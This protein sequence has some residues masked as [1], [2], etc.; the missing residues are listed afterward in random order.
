M[1]AVF[2]PCHCE[3]TEEGEKKKSIGSQIGEIPPITLPVSHSTHCITDTASAAALVAA[4]PLQT[5]TST[6]SLTGGTRKQAVRIDML[7]LFLYCDCI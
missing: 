2:L 6:H 7:S 5:H 1:L 4:H 3:R